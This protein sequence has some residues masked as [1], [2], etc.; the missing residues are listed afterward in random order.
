MS[1]DLPIHLYYN[2]LAIDANMSG[3]IIS[4]SQNLNGT[5][6]FAIQFIWTGTTPVGVS[7]LWVSNDDVNYSEI[8]AS[9]LAVT[10][11]TG[12]HIINV[13]KPGYSYVRAQYESTSGTGT[14]D[15]NINGK[16]G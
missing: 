5:I 2:D 10:G 16:R 3:N 6:S 4:S 14:M 15:I 7:S 8:P 12:N 1:N 13:E 11:N 9:V